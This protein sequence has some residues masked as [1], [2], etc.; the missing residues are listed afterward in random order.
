[1]DASGQWKLDNNGLAEGKILQH[2]LQEGLQEVSDTTIN[3]NDSDEHDIDV[4]NN[5]QLQNMM[6]ENYRNHVMKHQK[7]QP[8]PPPPQ[9]NKIINGNS[10]NSYSQRVCHPSTNNNNNGN[11]TSL[12]SHSQPCLFSVADQR[13]DPAHDYAHTQFH[14]QHS[15]DPRDENNLLNGPPGSK[16]VLNPNELALLRNEI[17]FLKQQNATL[18]K[19]SDK[20]KQLEHAYS[21]IDQEA[22]GGARKAKIEIEAQNTTLEEQRTHI[23]MLEKAL[24]NAQERLAAKERQAV[25]AVAVVDKCSHLQK[26]FARCSGR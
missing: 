3:N 12:M 23:E 8:P 22:N 1:M 4:S 16:I 19:K 5:E 20:L 9:H 15:S 11:S 13:L 26:L 18:Q 6:I 21:R 24:T 17:G 10:N 2:L 25:D 7:P 14:T